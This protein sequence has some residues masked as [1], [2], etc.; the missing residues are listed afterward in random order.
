MKIFT[1]DTTLRDGTQGE[2]VSF[3]AEDKIAIAEKLDDLGIDYIEGG[4]PGSNP[5]DKEFFELAR[6]LQWKHAKLTAFGAT[7]LAKNAVERDASVRE[8]IAAETPV[9]SIFGKTWDFHV[10]RALGITEEENLKLIGDTVAYLKSHGKEV[11][12]DAEHFFDGY[13]ANPN[14]AYQTLEAA[15]KG[16]ADVLC[17]CDTNGGTLPG[18]LADAVADV[19]KRFSGVIGIHCH[20]DSE[21]AVANTLA[22]VEAGAT[23]VQG[24][25]NGYGERCGNANLCSVVANLELKM[26]RRTIGREKLQNLTSVAHFVAELANLQLRRDQAFVGPSAFAHKGGVH[27]SAVMKDSATYEHVQ[28]ELVGNRQRVLLSDL[29]GRGN[30]SYK[31]HQL[32]LNESLPESARRELLQRIKQMEHEGYDFEASEGTFE[33]LVREAQQ[34][35]FHPFDVMGYEV[36]TKL[37]NGNGAGEETSTSASVTLRVGES[38]H[39]ETATGQGPVHALDICLRKC[40]SA[41]YPSIMNVR[42]VDYKVRVLGARGGTA[43]KVR[44]LVEWSDQEHGWSTVGISDNVIDASWRAL[45]DALRLELMRMLETGTPPGQVRTGQSRD[46]SWAV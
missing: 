1:F 37:Q 12:Y 46:F 11:V 32:G 23:H 17:L 13:F 10:R 38:L 45:V 43:A 34:P 28:P 8:L 41:I 44:V 30:V 2:S 27:V 5:K 40:L 39:S 24:C 29:S 21:V 16:G 25:I 9:V 4:W 33:L 31:L 35:D 14:Y 7:R 3:S 15:Q 36:T 18:R 42:L 26:G 22:A 19:C 20:N 6:G